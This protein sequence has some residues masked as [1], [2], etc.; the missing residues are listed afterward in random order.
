MSQHRFPCFKSSTQQQLDAHFSLTE[1][2]AQP[3]VVTSIALCG[4]CE[5]VALRHSRQLV[6]VDCVGFK[7]STTEKGKR[8]VHKSFIF[9]W[10]ERGT[11]ASRRWPNPENGSMF[12]HAPLFQRRECSA[13]SRRVCRIVVTREVPTF[14]N[15]WPDLEFLPWRTLRICRCIDRCR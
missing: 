11:F 13:R 5:R 4:G 8:H 12:W 15:A 6:C 2:A 14:H 10:L 3:L 7:I 9:A 1:S